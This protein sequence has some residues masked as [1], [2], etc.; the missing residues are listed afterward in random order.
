MCERQR[1]CA[2]ASE[3]V[4]SCYFNYGRFYVQGLIFIQTNILKHFYNFLLYIRAHLNFFKNFAFIT[5]RKCN[6]CEKKISVK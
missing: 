4:V 2:Y 5:V 6:L 1:Q 3:W